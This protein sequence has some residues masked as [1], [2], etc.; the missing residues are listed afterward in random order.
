MYLKTI[1]SVLLFVLFVPTAHSAPSHQ[2]L[3]DS[4]DQ[5]NTAK[6]KELLQGKVEINKPD[7]YGFTPLIWAASN[8]NIEIIELLLSHGA[9]PNFRNKDGGSALW[10]SVTNERLEALN[11]LLSK[12]AD[13]NI[14]FMDLQTPLEYCKERNWGKFPE[15]AK[16]LMKNEAN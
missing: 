14:K 15:I 6:V 3:I 8:G 16:I 5:N 2:D 12:G 11:V 10:Y 1:F 9:D 13:P 4:I 7:S